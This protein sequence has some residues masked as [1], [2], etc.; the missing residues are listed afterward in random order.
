MAERRGMAW[1]GQ[2]AQLQPPLHPPCSWLPSE[3]VYLSKKDLQ[4]ITLLDRREGFQPG[5]DLISKIS[6]GLTKLS[7]KQY[8]AGLWE[9]REVGAIRVGRILRQSLAC[10]R[11]ANGSEDPTARMRD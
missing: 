8:S 9:R 4:T 3:N 7:V 10:R 5:G 6:L 11:E 1:E 2:A